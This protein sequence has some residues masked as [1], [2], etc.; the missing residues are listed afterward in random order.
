MDNHHRVR[1]V[2]TMLLEALERLLAVEDAM[3]AARTGD[4]SKIAGGLRA[5]EDAQR[6][7]ARCGAMDDR[8]IGV[9]AE[10]AAFAI[11]TVTAYL[12]GAERG[13]GFELLGYSVAQA[14]AEAGGDAQWAAG[15][16]AAL[17]R[18]SGDLAI[19]V[20]A[21][22]TGPE[23]SDALAVIQRLARDVP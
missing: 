6:L 17:A 1:T 19:L 10:H 8:I 22:S 9:D 23:W 15:V 14:V 4:P 7:L 16:I 21:H 13:D 12:D 3:E 11:E 20:A 18:L 2:D 5:L